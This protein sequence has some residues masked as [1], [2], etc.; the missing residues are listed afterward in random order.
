MQDIKSNLLELGG[1]VAA[2]ASVYAIAWLKEFITNKAKKI[3]LDKKIGQNTKVNEKLVEL[4]VL[5]EADRVYLFQFHNGDYYTTGESVVRCTLSYIT[6]RTGVSFPDG[7]EH[8]YKGIPTS[9]ITSVLKPLL[10][11]PFIVE[12]VHNSIESDWK[13]AHQLNAEKSVIYVRVGQE[14]MH[15]LIMVAYNSDNDFSCLD[16]NNEDIMASTNELASL[17]K[18]SL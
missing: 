17:L 4:R 18:L 10:D 3:D 8:F 15:A 16:L 12:Q 14:K 9:R 6:V 5:L 11:S 1:Y 13:A 7:V 2:A